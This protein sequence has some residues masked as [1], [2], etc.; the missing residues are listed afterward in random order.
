MVNQICD[1]L[2][3]AQ[4]RQKS[5][6]DI[7]RKALELEIGDKVLLWVAPIKGVMRFGKKGKLSPRFVGPFEVLQRVGEVAYR[8][9]LPPTMSGIH[10]VFRESMLRKYIPHPSHVLSYKPL[11][12]R[13]DLSSEEVLVEILNCKEQVLHNRTISWVKVLWKNHWV[14]EA[15]WECEDNMLSRYPSLF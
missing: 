1:R 4:S 8:V 9:A 15:S 6:Y 2:R 5:Y 12:I 7:K 11:Q 10:N 13:D 14:K 3:A